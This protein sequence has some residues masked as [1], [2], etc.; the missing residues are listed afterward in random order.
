M[1]FSSPAPQFGPCCMS[2]SNTRLS[3]R[4]QLMRCGRTWTV[5]TSHSATAAVAAGS[6]CSSGPCGTTS[7][8]SFALGGSTPWQRSGVHF[9]QPVLDT[10]LSAAVHPNQDSHRLEV[11]AE[12]F[13]V[14]VMGR[15]TAPGDAIVTAEVF[16]KLIPLLQA[17]GVQTLGQARELGALEALNWRITGRAAEIAAVRVR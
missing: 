5:S 7:D 14:T 10:L 13:D 8:R 2:M 3:S 16:L 11:I 1:I 12:R 15:H 17:Q 4:A 6:S 9:D